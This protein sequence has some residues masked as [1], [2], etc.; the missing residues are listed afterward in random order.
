MCS[1]GW[2]GPACSCSRTWAWGLCQC[3]PSTSKLTSSQAPGNPSPSRHT[4]PPH[5]LI[6]YYCYCCCS[7]AG[8]ESHVSSTSSC[9]LFPILR[10]V[11][12][13]FWRGRF[14]LC[15]P[16]HSPLSYL[17]FSCLHSPTPSLLLNL[18]I[19]S[20]AVFPSNNYPKGIFMRGRPMHGSQM[21]RHPHTWSR[22]KKL[23]KTRNN[24]YLLT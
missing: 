23:L 2:Y 6:A 17:F 7:N 5:V 13:V 20:S 21:T 22:L 1:E 19:C 8:V 14:T 10:G 12:S 3:T 9:W 24:A 15:D 11:T 18:L 4:H 16:K